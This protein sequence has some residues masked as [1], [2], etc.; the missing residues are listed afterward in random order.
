MMKDSSYCQFDSAW[1]RF[2]TARTTIELCYVWK[3]HD[4]SVKKSINN[5]IQ[6]VIDTHCS[7]A[8]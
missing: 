8:Q 4:V 2:R 7:Q 3:E 6:F 5:Y 1:S